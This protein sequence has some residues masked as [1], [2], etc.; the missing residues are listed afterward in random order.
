MK[1]WSTTPVVNS[2][3]GRVVLFAVALLFTI[4]LP[5]QF[6]PKAQADQ[7]DDQINA[8][9]REID[10][11]QA[12]A[13]RLANQAHTLEAELA[14][15]NNERATIQGQIDLTQ[16][17]HD[18]L[19]ADITKT[20]KEI[21]TN[22]TALGDTIA[23]IYI[24]GS[25]SPLEMLASSN[26]IGDYVDK[27]EYQSSVR[28]ELVGTIARIETLRKQLEQQ[29]KDVENVLA[30]QKLAKDALVKKENERHQLIAQTRGEEAAYQNLITVQ[31]SAI[32]NL[33]QQQITANARF[34]GYAP[35]N[36]PACGG[37]YP[38]TWCNA[39][40]DTLIDDWGMFNRECVSYTAYKVAA[41]GRHMPYWGGIGN[42][43]Q[44]DDNARVSGIPVNSTPAVG[45]IAQT[46][47]GPYG[48][49]MYVEAVNS[50][51]TI[52]ISQY[53]AGFTGT[54]STAVISPSGLTFIHF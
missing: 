43:N 12:E 30:D 15:L 34:L 16:A 21:K 40:I 22:K 6:M 51:G 45:A 9:Q 25:I 49:V 2:K 10:I 27:Q 54:Y 5:L 53:N 52:S 11:Y 36:G 42:A 47:A 1:Q 3:R 35:G 46:D 31:G 32:S 48:H 29:K 17:K 24:D 20:E 38:G 41:S 26:N 50:D 23:Q 28:D 39:P 7:F 19:V 33:R 14:K 44:W 13:G 37:G 4:S 18:K 8:I